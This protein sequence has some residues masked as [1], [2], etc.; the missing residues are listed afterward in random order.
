MQRLPAD[1]ARLELLQSLDDCGYY[2]V[3]PTPLTHARA[4]KAV[5]ARAGREQARSLRDIFGWSLPFAR[6]ELDPAL[7]DLLQRA[8]AVQSEGTHYR[9]LLRVSRLHGGLYLHSAYP[10]RAT[11]A[12]FFGPDTYRFANFVRAEL[13]TSAT[14]L[15]CV[16]IG[17]GSGAGAISAAA[18]LPTAHWT[19][20]DINPQALR[21]ASVNAEHAVRAMDCVRSDVLAGTSGDFDL[22]ISNPPYMV[23]PQRRAYRDGGAGLGRALSLR[24]VRE[25]LPR[26]NEGGR[27]LLYTGIAMVD[28][29]DPF[30]AELRPLLEGGGYRWRYRELDP[31]VFGAELEQPAYAEVERIA[32]VGLVVNRV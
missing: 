5:L 24:I 11:D 22:I 20:A 10:T 3:T 13:P 15:R 23:D 1:Q 7:F 2:F 4:L 29:V 8:D 6:T 30:L 31:D 32:A 25:A 12:V 26:L 21:L 18:R 9:S 14:P 27:L 16:D 28:G 17:C 19:L